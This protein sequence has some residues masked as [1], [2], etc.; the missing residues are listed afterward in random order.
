[1]KIKV[2]FLLSLCF[3]VLGQQD[4]KARSRQKEIPILAWYSIPPGENATEERYRELKD[5]GFNYSFSHI[6]TKK[7]ALRALDLCRKV[8]MKSIFM[9]PELKSETEATV[10]QVRR[11]RALGGYFLR[12]EPQ[13]A[14]LEELGKWARRVEAA[15]TK[16]PCYLNLLPSWAFSKSEY[17]EHLRLFDKQVNLPLLSFDHYPLLRKGKEIFVRA[18]FY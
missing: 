8:G 14:D 3:V 11:H 1:M 18:E 15:D 4:I 10:K 7:D 9:C 6:Y 13:N 5:C 17:E 16:H 2:V 12:D